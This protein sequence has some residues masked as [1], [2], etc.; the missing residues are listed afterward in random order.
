MP[1]QPIARTVRST[2]TQ[3][4]RLF[5]SAGRHTD[6][7]TVRRRSQADAGGRVEQLSLIGSQISS[8]LIG[9]LRLSLQS[10][11]HFSACLSTSCSGSFTLSLFV[12][13]PE[14]PTC[15]EGNL[16]PKVKTAETGLVWTGMSWISP[17]YHARAGLQLVINLLLNNTSALP[18]VAAD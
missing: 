7:V 6:L 12:Q 9:W 13:L 16:L 18:V 8:V 4:N 14:W 5:R 11:I 15:P 2:L 3:W 10:F 1:C 17:P